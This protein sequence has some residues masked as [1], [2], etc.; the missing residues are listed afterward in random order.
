MGACVGALAF[1]GLLV[2]AQA[3]A[4][5]AFG[6]FHVNSGLT[7]YVYGAGVVPPLTKAFTFTTGWQNDYVPIDGGRA[8]AFAFPGGTCSGSSSLQLDAVSMSSGKL[9]W[10]QALDEVNS[11]NNL[12]VVDGGR[13]FAAVSGQQAGCRRRHHPVGDQREHGAVVWRDTLPEQVF[14]NSLIAANRTLYLDG[15]GQKG[16]RSTR[17]TSPTA[18]GNATVDTYDANPLT[19]AGDILVLTGTD[20]DSCA[21]SAP[22]GTLIW[23]RSQYC[24]GGGQ[25]LA[26]HDGTHLWGEDPGGGNEGYVN[27]VSTG[28]VVNRFP[29]YA[30]AVGYHEAVHD[31]TSSAGTLEIQA[32]NPNSMSTLWTFTEPNASTDPMESMLFA[33][34]RVRVRRGQPRYRLG[35]ETPAT[36][37]R[38]VGLGRFQRAL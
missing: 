15:S 14:P 4:A 3:R 12:L 16:A 37:L 13:V 32:F 9:A 7:G 2:P 22:T 21:L 24:S 18:R 1:S 34:R 30:P 17:S 19:L 10:S 28:G 26:S 25:G 23:Q 8:Y 27:N 29:G 6:Q 20:A 35:A 38:S 33:S 36:A 11:T 31:V 5:A